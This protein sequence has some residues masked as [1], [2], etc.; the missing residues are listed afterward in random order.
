MVLNL[1]PRLARDHE[2]M[3]LKY[4]GY[5]LECLIGTQNRGALLQDLPQLGS[6]RRRIFP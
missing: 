2:L 3:A 6:L 4:N 1:L 5:T